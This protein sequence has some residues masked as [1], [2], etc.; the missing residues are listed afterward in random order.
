MLIGNRAYEVPKVN[1]ET[2]NWDSDQTVDL[3]L[4]KGGNDKT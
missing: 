1:K 4:A 2:G 3:E